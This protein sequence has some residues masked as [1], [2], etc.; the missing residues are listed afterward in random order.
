MSYAWAWHRRLSQR[1]DA[2]QIR[3]ALGFVAQLR[4]SRILLTSCTGN[5]SA[6]ATE[7]LQKVSLRRFC[8][9]R[10]G[11][12]GTL[13]SIFGMSVKMSKEL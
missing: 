5:G 1:R 4:P 13:S 9:H 12:S 2:P 10:A 7:D 3:L 8:G 6:D 11:T